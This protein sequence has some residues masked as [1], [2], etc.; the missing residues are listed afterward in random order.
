MKDLMQAKE[1]PAAIAKL[2]NMIRERQKDFGKVAFVGI[3]TRGVPVAERLYKLFRDEGKA[4]LQGKLD[5]NLYR[6]DLSESAEQPVLKSTEVPFDVTGKIIY[7]CDDVLYTGR[8]VRAAM[9]AVFDLGRPSQLH[10]VVMA[11]RNGRELPIDTDVV[12]IDVK[13][14]DGD[15]VKVKFRETDDHDGITLLEKGDY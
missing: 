5:I 14:K 8:T 12:G 1:V 2:A 6:D 11:R 4:V 7:L 3:H 10:L 13:T 15:N 9:D